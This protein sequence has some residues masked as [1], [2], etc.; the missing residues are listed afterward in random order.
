MMDCRHLKVGPTFPCPR[1]WL[2]NGK[3]VNPFQGETGMDLCF[4]LA[5]VS[6]GLSSNLVLR[7]DAR[8]IA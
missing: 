8:H 5:A 2:C 1:P 6:A 7:Y 3:T 4:H